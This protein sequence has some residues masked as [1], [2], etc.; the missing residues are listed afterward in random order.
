MW[1]LPNTFWAE[2]TKEIEGAI[3]IE[4]MMVDK[5]KRFAESAAQ[6]G[7]RSGNSECMRDVRLGG[8][9]SKLILGHI[10]VKRCKRVLGLVV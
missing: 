4:I 2:R 9:L 6:L 7:L 10:L 8:I 1:V 5:L 3:L